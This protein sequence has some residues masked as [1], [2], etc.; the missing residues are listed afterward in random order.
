M[1][2]EMSGKEWQD[3]FKDVSYEIKRVSDNVQYT[4]LVTWTRYYKTIFS[5]ELRYAGMLAFLLAVS[6]HV[7]IF[8][9]S[10]CSNSSL[11]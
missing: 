4:I 3:K 5:L 2:L 9:Q 11:V 1:Q 8:N 10:D 6:N 7:T